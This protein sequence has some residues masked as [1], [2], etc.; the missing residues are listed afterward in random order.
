MRRRAPHSAERSFTAPGAR[1]CLFSVCLYSGG[2]IW[3]V[4]CTLRSS[5]ARCRTLHAAAV[6]SGLQARS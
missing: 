1:V 3:L 6:P 4:R 5:R 2:A